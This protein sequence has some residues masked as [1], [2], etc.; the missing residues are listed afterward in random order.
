MN[1]PTPDEIY[2][3][4]YVRRLFDE[5][6]STYG[7]V[8]LLS[9]FG[10]T[11]W[12]R[13]ACVRQIDVAAGGDALDLMTG[14]GELCTLISR[15]LGPQGRL[16]AI[17]LSPVMCRRAAKHRFEHRY[18]VIQADALQCPLPD[19]SIDCI[20]SSFGLKTFNDDQIERLA[21]EVFRVL[22]PGGQFSFLEVSVPPSRWLRCL[23]LFYLCRVVPVIGRVL[24]GNPDNYRLLGV[25][26]TAFH[27]CD[28]T[29]TALE[30]NGLR[31]QKKTFFFGCATGVVGQRPV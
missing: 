10:F 21:G 29:A 6:A 14:M 2:R 15:S 12:W 11:V 27:N 24:M 4:D 13:R 9:S 16:R 22:K 18:R 31:V 7:V 19:Q 28:A 5:M 3:Q 25:Y 1:D 30:R 20:F 17:D 23:Y 26:T 8:N